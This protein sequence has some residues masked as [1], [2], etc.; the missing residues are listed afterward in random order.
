[1]EWVDRHGYVDHDRRMLDVCM[2]AMDKAFLASEAEQRA[3]E[4]ARRAK[5]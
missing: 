2:Q 3:A 4:A 1:M 5:Q